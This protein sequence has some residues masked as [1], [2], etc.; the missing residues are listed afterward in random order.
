MSRK[1]LVA[2]ATKMRST[3]EIAAGI[4][5]EI[6]GHGHQVDI[7]D[8]RDVRSVAE[9]DAVVIGSAIYA[10]RWRPEA[11]RFLHRFAD[12]L[13]NRQAWLF[14]SGP[15]GPHADRMQAMPRNVRRLAE[16]IGAEPAMTFAG[17]LDPE[18]AKGLLA[19]RMAATELSGDV[20]D[21]DLIGAWAED[22]ATAI[23]TSEA[24]FWNRAEPSQVS[25]TA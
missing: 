5:A 14:N 2:Y 22:V 23:T 7:R 11:V 3:A 18:T 21:W 9:Y 1:V 19:R 10:Q 6:T 25:G 4:G 12:D 8:V 15:V 20:R 24:G 17:R 13:R 16:R